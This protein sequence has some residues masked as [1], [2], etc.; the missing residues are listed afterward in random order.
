LTIDR[1]LSTKITLRRNIRQLPVGARNVYPQNEGS[2]WCNKIPAAG[3][4]AGA[5]K[6]PA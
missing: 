1:A 6:S 2:Y 4:R 5:R 3:A